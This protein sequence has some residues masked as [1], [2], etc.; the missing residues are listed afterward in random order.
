VAPE[1]L[2]P[3]GMCNTATTYASSVGTDISAYDD[4]PGY[5][6]LAARNLI[7]TDDES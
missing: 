2:F 7:A 6:L 4:L 1:P 3:H 5:H